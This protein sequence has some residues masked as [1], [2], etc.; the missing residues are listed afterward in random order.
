MP[1]PRGRSPRAGLILLDLCAINI[2]FAA[3]YSLRY[4]AELGG[5]I[6]WYNFV[7]YRDYLGWGLSLSLILL[8]YFWI[9]GLYGA[10]ARQSLTA[11]VYTLATG[12]FVGLGLVAVLV[13]AL[14]P[15]AQ[16]RLMLI[17]AAVLIVASLVVVRLADHVMFMRRLRRGDG[18]TRTLIVGAGEKGR[19]VMRN[20]VAQPNLGYRVIGFL[21]DN[22]EKRAASIGRFEPLGGTRD[23][24]RVLAD[25]AVD[26]VVI[27]LPWRSRST[28]IRHVD[29]CDAAGVSVRIVPDLFQMSLNRVDMDS[30][31][32][33]PLIAVT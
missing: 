26:M 7:P 10:R 33:L 1:T 29:E 18:V 14:R 17:Y 4:E 19:T 2:A 11:T 24:P 30:L 8:A 5:P 27:A 23:L 6:D 21:D 12:T 13:F 9:E 32:G 20:I 28:I 25:E 31:H 22:P 15:L 16:S 3:A